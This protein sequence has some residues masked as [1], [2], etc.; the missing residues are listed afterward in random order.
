LSSAYPTAFISLV[1]IQN[2]PINLFDFIHFPSSPHHSIRPILNNY[3][4][5]TSHR[6]T[7][8]HKPSSMKW[9]ALPLSALGIPFNDFFAATYFIA[10]SLIKI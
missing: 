4:S 3:I 6:M 2:S 1:G 8:A 10:S 9:L 7:V 5:A